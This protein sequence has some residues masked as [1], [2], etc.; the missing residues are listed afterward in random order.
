MEAEP[1]ADYDAADQVL[2][3][4]GPGFY[5]LIQMPNDELLSLWGVR[6]ESGPRGDRSG[7][8]SPC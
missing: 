2:Q 3:I 5:L 1:E 6:E 7:P 8:R 4:S